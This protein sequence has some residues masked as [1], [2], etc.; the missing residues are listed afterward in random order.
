MKQLYSLS[1]RWQVTIFVSSTLITILTYL[2][3]YHSIDEV[4]WFPF[5]IA[6]AVNILKSLVDFG[7][8][9]VPAAARSEPTP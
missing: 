5:G 7:M 6:C 9:R 8:G 1:K 3:A 2:G 4:M